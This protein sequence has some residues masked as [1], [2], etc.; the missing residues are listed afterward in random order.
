MVYRYTEPGGN[1]AV[2]RDVNRPRKSFWHPFVDFT[3]DSYDAAQVFAD[4]KD[5]QGGETPLGQFRKSAD[6]VVSTGRNSRPTPT[7][8][9]PVLEEMKDE[10]TKGWQSGPK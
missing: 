4:I 1:G 7:F 8:I 10:V 6:L 5:W 9:E 3:K 2:E